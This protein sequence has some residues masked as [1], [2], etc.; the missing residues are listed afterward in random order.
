MVIESLGLLPSS[1][2]IQAMDRFLEGPTTD[3]RDFVATVKRYCVDETVD[4][5]LNELNAP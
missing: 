3:N 1:L 5:L 2:A 4:L